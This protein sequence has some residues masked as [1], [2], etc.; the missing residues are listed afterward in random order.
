MEKRASWGL[1]V[2][3]SSRRGGQYTFVSTIH[4]CLLLDFLDAF[5]VLSC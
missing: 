1:E 4:I 2:I 3:S 5:V